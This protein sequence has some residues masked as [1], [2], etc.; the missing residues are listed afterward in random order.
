MINILLSVLGTLGFCAIL[1]V[2]KKSIIYVIIGSFISAFVY[3]ILFNYYMLDTFISS[4]FASFSIGIYSEIIARLKKMPS[5]V[6]F[7][8]SSIPLLPGGSLYYAM[9]NLVLKNNKAFIKY[10]IDTLNTG[11]GI[12]LGALATMICVFIIRNLRKKQ[13]EP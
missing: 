5:T 1:N 10:A 4:F 3:E 12:A 11:A 7:L 2:R 13:K 9:N 8:P 6:I